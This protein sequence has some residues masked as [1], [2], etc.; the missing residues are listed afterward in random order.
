MAVCTAPWIPDTHGWQFVCQYQ[1]DDATG[2]ELGDSRI[3]LSAIGPD[4]PSENPDADFQAIWSLNKLKNLAQ[5]LVAAYLPSFMM[6]PVTDGDGDQLGEDADGAGAYLAPGSS[7]WTLI[8]NSPAAEPVT[9]ELQVKGRYQ[10]TWQIDGAAVTIGV[11]GLGPDDVT[12]IQA[13]L[14]AQFGESATVQSV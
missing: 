11:A 4:G 14:T 12:R 9:P 5:G 3:A 8:D 7:G 10:P 6:T 1:T 13:L 2:L